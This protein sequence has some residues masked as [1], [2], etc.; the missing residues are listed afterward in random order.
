MKIVNLIDQFIDFI[1]SKAGYIVGV[2]LVAIVISLIFK[3][4]VK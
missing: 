1:D 3:V 4:L 2:F